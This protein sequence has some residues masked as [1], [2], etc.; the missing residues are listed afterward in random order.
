MNEAYHGISSV[1]VLVGLWALWAH[2][3]ETLGATAAACGTRKPGNCNQQSEPRSLNDRRVRV[4]CAAA[5]V[6]PG[7]VARCCL[8]LSLIPPQL[9]AVPKPMLP[10]PQLSLP[11]RGLPGPAHAPWARQHPTGA[12]CG[13]PLP[14]PLSEGL[15][16]PL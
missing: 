14:L 8:S 6:R 11:R 12:A 10:L 2:E 13:L 16:A 1:L 5:E 9:A 7:T 4:G 3:E 15:S